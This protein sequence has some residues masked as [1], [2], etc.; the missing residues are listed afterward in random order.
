MAPPFWWY[1]IKRIYCYNIKL[2]SDRGSRGIMETDSRYCQQDKFNRLHDGYSKA[3]TVGR[4]NA[5]SKSI[6]LSSHRFVP[7]YSSIMISIYLLYQMV[8]FVSRNWPNAGQM[9]TPH[10]L[11]YKKR[12]HKS[13]KLR[14]FSRI[15]KTLR[16]L[17]H[18]WKNLKRNSA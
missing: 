7:P 18:L 12:Y 6:P 15:P 10:L 5:T 9:C 2:I 3:F 13:P 1:W 14:K 11:N 8:W 17:K 4:R 16:I